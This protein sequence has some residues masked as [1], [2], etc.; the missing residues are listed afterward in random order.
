MNYA[1]SQG[2]HVFSYDRLGIGESSH[3]DPKNEIQISLE[4][5][6]LA[7]MTRML[8]NGSVHDIRST[9]TKIVHVGHS[10]GS[11][12][13][14][15]LSA[16][17]PD[18]SDAIILTGFSSN[19]NFLPTFVAGGNLQQARLHGPLPG[20]IVSGLSDYRSGYLANTNI[21]GNQ[22]QFFHAPEFDSG[23]LEFSELNK[24]PLTIGEMMTQGGVPKQSRFTGP[25]Y[26]ITGSNDE[27]FCG[28]NCYGTDGAAMSIP[29]ASKG[30]FPLAK[31][32]LAFVQPNTGHGINLHYTA[33]SAYKNIHDFLEAHD[34]ARA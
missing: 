20:R 30:V 11:V 7:E 1:L 19:A 15:A 29:A 17:Y 33:T 4:I 9:P 22:Y 5:E 31:P 26:I 10:F 18:M 23:L 13:T 3:G 27:P 28:G 2:Y 8:R 34:F 6:A 21:I 14:Y 25:V 16:M 32:F 24:Q 12:Q